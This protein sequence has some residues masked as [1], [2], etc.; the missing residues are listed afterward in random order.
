MNRSFPFSDNAVKHKIGGM[1]YGQQEKLIQ[2]TH[3]DIKYFDV[4]V[5]TF[6][7]MLFLTV[8]P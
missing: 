1:F 2:G 3:W 5:Q 7:I 6:V 8:F 4:E